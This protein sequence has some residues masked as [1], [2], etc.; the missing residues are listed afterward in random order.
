MLAIDQ[1]DD[2]T[3]DLRFAGEDHPDL[4]LTD[5]WRT[6]TELKIR[7]AGEMIRELKGSSRD[8]VGHLIDNGCPNPP[9]DLFPWEWDDD[10]LKALCDWA[11]PS[12]TWP[13]PMGDEEINRGLEKAKTDRELGIYRR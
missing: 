3:E 1:F 5:S 13:A 11:D 7:V 9:F 10:K 2:T 4:R 6:D 12:V 8:I